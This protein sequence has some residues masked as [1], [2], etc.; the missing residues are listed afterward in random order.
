MNFN[1]YEED[2]NDVWVTKLY[3][4]WNSIV[5]KLSL[6]KPLK[7]PIFEVNPNISKKWGSWSPSTRIMT[8][9]S[10]LLNNFE[11]GAVEYVMKH[12]V[13]H[14]IVS[15]VFDM[16]CYGVSHGEFFGLACE[17]VGIENKRCADCGFLSSFKGKED[18]PLINKIKKLMN[19]S[20]NESATEAES[21]LF[22][23]KAQQ[24][25]LKY[26][27]DMKEVVDIDRVFVKRPFGGL[28]KSWKSYMWTL[29]DLLTEH[30]DVE[31]IR[32]YSRINNVDRKSVV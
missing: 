23:N 28:Y 18:N 9:S 27:I 14:Q 1:I 19:H 12:E 13:C 20:S 22:M 21:E 32:T 17:I 5:F 4:T 31:C 16:D 26:D 10:K 30:Y 8:F 11:W 29:G 2:C 3:D 24:L 7:A 6:K 15:E 25:M